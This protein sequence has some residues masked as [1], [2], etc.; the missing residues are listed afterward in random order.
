MLKTTGLKR[1]KCNRFGGKLD[2]EIKRIV[3]G[4]F[5]A[6]GRMSAQQRSLTDFIL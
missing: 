6:A 2:R 4:L 1:K 5:E 3:F